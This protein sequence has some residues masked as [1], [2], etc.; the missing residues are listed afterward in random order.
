MNALG[1][2]TKKIVQH[3]L[4]K[5][6]EDL[7]TKAQ[8][9]YGAKGSLAIEID[10]DEAGRWFDHESKVGGGIID[11][12]NREKGFANGEAWD[13]LADELGIKTESKWTTTGTYVYR[14]RSGR[15]LYRVVRKDCEGKPKKIY[16]ERYDEA[17]GRF[18]GE[19]GCMKGVRYVPYRLNEWVDED[20]LVLIAE[21]ER[22]VDEL[23][24]LGGLGTCNAGGAG[25][26][27]RGFAPYFSDRDVVILPDNDSVG[28]DH[29][30]QVAE[31]LEPVA[32]SV[33]ILELPGL[34]DKGDI[35][36]WLAA[37]GTADQ[38]RVLIEAAP[39][40]AGVMATWV[41]E[42]PDETSAPSAGAQIQK[43]FKLTSDG[44]YHEVEYKEGNREW[45]WI[46][47]PIEVLAETRDANGEAWGRLLRIPDRDGINHVW[48]MPMKML[49]GAGIEYRER[50]LELG[51]ELAPGSSA[52][53]ALHTYLSVWRPPGR[54]R[55]VERTGWHHK[56][57]VLPD[58]TCGET[59]GEPVLLQAPGTA[60][61]YDLDGTL[62]GWRREV[63]AVAVGNSRLVLAISAA[64]AAPLLHLV[65]EESGGVHLCGASSTGK[66]T[67]G[68]VAASVWG[69]PRRSWRMTT[70]AAESTSR[71]SCDALLFLDEI[72]QAEPWDIDAMA[73]LIGN[74]AGKGRMKRDATARET[75]TW[76]TLFL[77]TGEIGLLAKLSEIGRRPRAG[78]A[79]RLIEIPADAGAGLGL[80]EDLHGHA[81]GDALARHLKLA[82]KA[83]RGYAARAFIERVAGEFDEVAETIGEIRR[84]WV[85][86]H[87]AD[88]ADGQ[89]RRA[90]GRFALLAAAGE[91][92]QMWGVV[93][94]PEGEADRAA[95]MCFEAW[96]A[97]R[98]G[99]E[100]QEIIEGLAQAQK[101]L[102]QHGSDRFERAWDV[103]RD[104][105]GNETPDRVVNRAGFR[106]LNED[107]DFEYFVLPE[108]W[109]RE[110]C[111]G[112]DHL[113]IARAMVARGWLQREGKDLTRK[114]RI[115]R[116]GSVRVYHVLPEALA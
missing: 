51:A 58:V 99:S 116:H 2:H 48:A 18:I 27:S 63:G 29:A 17:S 40:A 79:M 111:K 1:P 101:F 19:K 90:A 42:E 46:A 68:D 37:G 104:R 34:P 54:A 28:R 20:G 21:G 9:R 75:L 84:R 5:P 97:T 112:C 77:S 15:P 69:V 39:P 115:P 65:C 73:Y 82:A 74:E 113:T 11:L 80:F 94:W 55:C 70:N 41:P 88:D 110:V 45:I 38:L 76:R 96:L 100:P 49:A 83:H 16:Q 60:P 36:D 87:V 47:S 25:K 7:S 50:L 108:A 59:N 109:K 4:G 10:G 92:A 24:R 71:G 64:F 35:V 26:F 14:D 12:I 105:D 98:G 61:Q 22:K 62:D 86:Q 6:N 23:V 102:E 114:M 78:Q 3:L 8:W 85:E 52:K 67:A 32:A 72:G 93:P 30:R 13:W 44:V 57:F 31:I 107:G 95:Q 91:L 103:R 66:T 89:V 33:P 81:N 43:G 53:G 56:V 106:R